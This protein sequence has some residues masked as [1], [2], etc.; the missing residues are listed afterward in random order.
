MRDRVQQRQ[1]KQQQQRWAVA[2]R[3]ERRITSVC[4][5]GVRAR[6]VFFFLLSRAVCGRARASVS[7]TLEAFVVFILYFSR[8]L[9]FTSV[10]LSFKACICVAP[11]LRTSYAHRR[12]PATAC[13]PLDALQANR[14]AA[15]SPPRPTP[16]HQNP[17]LTVTPVKRLGTASRVQGT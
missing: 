15:P 7:L 11:D 13:F 1:Q 17:H 3:Q 12:L 8:L 5:C 16:T 6:G 2:L 10:S 4:K 9:M 14:T